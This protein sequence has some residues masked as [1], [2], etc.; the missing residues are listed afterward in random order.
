MK[1]SMLLAI[2][3]AGLSLPTFGATS[4]A[5]YQSSNVNA[6]AVSSTHDVRPYTK[7]DGTYVEGHKAGNPGSGVH[8]RNNVCY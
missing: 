8:C 3:F 7:R 1:K 5:M 4:H 2:C 6:Y